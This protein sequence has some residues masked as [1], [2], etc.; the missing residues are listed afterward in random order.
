MYNEDRLA[1]MSQRL[2][3]D[4]H[5]NASIGAYN[6]DNLELEYDNDTDEEQIYRAK[7]YLLSES[8]MAIEFVVKDDPVMLVSNLKN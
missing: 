4:V 6:M 8:K 1:F 2:P 5:E 7:K 3:D